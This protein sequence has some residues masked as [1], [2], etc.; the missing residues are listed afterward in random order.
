MARMDSLVFA[1]IIALAGVAAGVLWKFTAARF[2]GLINR[3]RDHYETRISTHGSLDSDA[4]HKLAAELS[5]ERTSA[6][7]LQALEVRL[8]ELEAGQETSQREFAVQREYHAL[9]LAQS[10]VSFTLGYVF[11]ALGALVVLAGAV[12]ALFLA[13]TSNQAIVGILTATAGVIP[14]ALAGLLF[15]SASRAGKTMAENFDRGRADRDLA[16]AQHIAAEMQDRALGDR[17]QAVLALSMAH[18]SIDDAALQLVH[19]LDPSAR[20]V[21]DSPGAREQA[22]DQH[23]EHLA[24]GR[25]E[26]E[27]HA[28]ELRIGLVGSQHRG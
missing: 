8:A 21:N 27:S 18:A 19:Q 26:V 6:G 15:V 10:K 23:L 1:P 25:R 12:K 17:L 13:D 14:E 9:G 4:L 2:D 20:A 5:R 11:G 24:Q 22:G 16:A 28:G 7:G 3:E